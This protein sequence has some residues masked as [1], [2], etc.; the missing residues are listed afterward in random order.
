[1]ADNNE[2]VVNKSYNETVYSKKWEEFRD[3][4]Y[5]EYRKKWSQ[6]P[7]DKIVPD[8]PL[9]LDIETTNACNLRC[10]MCPRT[11][12]IEKDNFSKIGFMTKDDYANIIDQAS[13]YGAYSIK[14][15]YLGEPLLHKDVV[16]QVEYAKK[17]GLV[18]VMFNTNGALLTK[19]LSMQSNVPLHQ[20]L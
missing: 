9:H 5:H 16:W 4:K 12:L 3:E 10:P 14:L 19:D 2:Y 8:F 20:Q 7:I 13:K 1:M 15:N 11:I 18:D 6:C 17:K